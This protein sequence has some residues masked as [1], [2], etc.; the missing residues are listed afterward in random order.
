[1]SKARRFAGSVGVAVLLS[2][3]CA[4]PALATLVE[5]RAT[6]LVDV[7]PGED[8]W[9]YEYFLS[10]RSFLADQG[11]SIYF[12]WM[13][14]ANLQVPP[15]PVADWDLLTLQ[16][17]LAL[18]AD[19]FFDGLALLDGASLASPFSV[20]FIWL[21]GAGLAP[22]SQAFEVYDLTGGFRVIERGRT[23]AL[24]TMPVPEPSTLPLLGSGLA[25]ALGW[26]RRR[27]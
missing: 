19:G 5:Y 6:D 16:P 23:V 4:S 26:R 24:G 10:G 27:A 7:V 9:L 3:G 8:L 22:G 20:S 12:D 14:F 1:M 25:F 13:R 18:P 15:P 17:D 21:G 11:F 2:L